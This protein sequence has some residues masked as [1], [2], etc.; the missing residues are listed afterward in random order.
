MHAKLGEYYIFN[1]DSRN[2]NH[3]HKI[4]YYAH[5]YLGQ[6]GIKIIQCLF[7]YYAF[8]FTYKNICTVHVVHT[9]IGVQPYVHAKYICMYYMCV[10]EY[11]CIY[12]YISLLLLLFGGVLSSH[13]RT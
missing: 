12:I 11:V 2:V 9:Q 10:C 7:D 4:I 6:Q 13:S 3:D 5:N 8:I 1:Y